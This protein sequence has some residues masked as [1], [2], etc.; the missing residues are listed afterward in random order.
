MEF[1]QKKSNQYTSMIKDYALPDHID[2][3]SQLGNQI[4]NIYGEKQT[5]GAI[6][7]FSVNHTEP[8]EYTT[9]VKERQSKPRG[10]ALEMYDF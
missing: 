10:Q 4:Q 9:S 5:L 8:V 1:N 6:E 3:Y 7:Q 2:I